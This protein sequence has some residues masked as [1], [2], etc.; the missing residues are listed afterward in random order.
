MKTKFFYPMILAMGL[1]FA[2]STITLNGQTTKNNKM[3]QKKTTYTCPMHP[4]VSKNKPGKCSKCGMELVEN[5]KDMKN[6][7][8][9]D[10]NMK[11]GNMNNGNM[12]N[13]NMSDS[14][15]IN[16]PDSTKMNNNNNNMPM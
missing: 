11:D 15:N 12:N 6:G 10:G 8:K 9:K 1:F 16:M 2:G 4:E 7:N 13:D 3:D 14:T 5:T